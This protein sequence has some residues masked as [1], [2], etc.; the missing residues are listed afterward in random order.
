MEN[1]EP[2]IE[3]QTKDPEEIKAFNKVLESMAK[4][5]L[6]VGNTITKR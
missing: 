6:L 3:K 5:I 2:I 4:R 1:D